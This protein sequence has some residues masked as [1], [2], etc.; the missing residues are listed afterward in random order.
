MLPISNT[1]FLK[2]NFILPIIIELNGKEDSFESELSMNGTFRIDDVESGKYIGT[3]ME[4]FGLGEVGL[5]DF[6]V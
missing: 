6:F 5:G 3:P 1:I 2:G 4:N